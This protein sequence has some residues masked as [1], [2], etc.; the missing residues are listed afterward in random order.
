MQEPEH[1]Y[2]L[3]HPHLPAEFLPLKTPGAL[4]N[5]LPKPTS[6]FVGRERNVKEV[7]RLLAMTRS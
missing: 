4:P 5:N 7:G 2:Q 1:I 3:R 6:S